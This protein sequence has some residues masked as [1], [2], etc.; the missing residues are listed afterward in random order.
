MK[1]YH[2]SPEL[3]HVLVTRRRRE[4]LNSSTYKSPIQGAITVN[5]YNDSL[6]K[7]QEMGLPGS[8]FDHVSF[9]FE[10]IPALHIAKIFDHGHHTWS[11]G[12]VLY[13]H[14]VEFKDLPKDF[15]YEI[16]E[17]PFDSKFW[18]ENMPPNPDVKGA[19]IPGLKILTGLKRK[20]GLIGKG[21]L[22]QKASNPFTTGILEAYRKSRKSDMW[23]NAK[24]LYAGGVP[25]VMIYSQIGRFPVKSV[26]QIT[27][28]SDKRDDFSSVLKNYPLS[29][30][31]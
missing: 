20:N 8:Y 22:L 15:E 30:K 13:E 6:K 9:F 17:T 21:T 27:I 1:L 7:A 29:T 25:H 10:P 28:G 3:R 31:W 24:N 23:E 2:Y 11:D 26:Y 19:F 18:D 5:E 4:P 14:V 12:Q 16:V